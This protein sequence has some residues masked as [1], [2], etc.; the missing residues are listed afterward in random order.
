MKSQCRYQGCSYLK[1][2]WW[3]KDPLPR[4]LTNDWPVVTDSLTSGMSPFNVELSRK[5]LKCPH[6][7]TA[8]FLQWLIQK[9]EAE[10]TLSFTTY[11]KL[12][13]VTSTIVHRSHKTNLVWY[14][15]GLYK[16]LNIRSENLWGI[17]RRLATTPLNKFY[18]QIC[19]LPLY[20]H[21]Y[22]VEIWLCT[23]SLFCL[24]EHRNSR[25]K[26]KNGDAQ[27]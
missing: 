3:L 7:M 17:S 6:D 25:I 21:F 26:A 8:E 4:W 14:G 19:K 12:P 15:R 1:V 18:V 20:I 5:L 27:P 9:N 23:C 24:D 13:T 10:E 2:W 22:L 16:V 11:P